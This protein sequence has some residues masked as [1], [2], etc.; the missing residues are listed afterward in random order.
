VL[1]ATLGPSWGVYSGYELCENEPA[2]EANEEYAHSEKYEIK[3]R[4]FADP[5]SIGGFLAQLNDIRRR[6]PALTDLR[7]LRFHDTT[8]EALIAYSKQL[9]A[10]TVL[11]VVS[12]DPFAVAEGSV[13]IDLGAL[14]LP[15]DEALDA[16]DE[17]TGERFDW[18]GP[19]TYLRLDP[20]RPAH[21][22]HLQALPAPDVP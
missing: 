20:D 19:H 4:D 6:H 10:D 8:S 15:W 16:R 7:S 11:V 2:S 13:W 3:H 12:I 18:R 1:A 21:V 14:G 9:G 22:V 17:L 5:R